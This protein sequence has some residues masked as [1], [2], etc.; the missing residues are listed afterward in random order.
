M[1]LVLA[2]A[3]PAILSSS[4]TSFTPLKQPYSRTLSELKK[5]DKV[6]LVLTSGV[7]T[8][9]L[10]VEEAWPDSVKMKNDIHAIPVGNIRQ[11]R[12]LKFDPMLTAVGLAIPVALIVLITKSAENIPI[13]MTGKL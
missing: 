12:K 9:R 5:G 13:S 3:L 7:A 6:K 11:I 2:L 8:G 4:C 10:V 1:V